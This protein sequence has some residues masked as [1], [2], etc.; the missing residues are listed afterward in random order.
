[1]W[2]H[3]IF[4]FLALLS[5]LGWQLSVRP[6][7]WFITITDYYLDIM[8]DAKHNTIKKLILYA[9]F[10]RN[11]VKLNTQQQSVVPIHINRGLNLLVLTVLCIHFSCCFACLFVCFFHSFI[12]QLTEVY[13]SCGKPCL[14]FK[15]FE[16]SS[17]VQSFWVYSVS[18]NI[19]I[20]QH[21]AWTNKLQHLG[22]S[23]NYESVKMMTYF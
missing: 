9:I 11:T 18:S 8:L 10:S 12:S 5:K 13:I 20:V 4:A 22:I 23:C 17:S 7:L 19:S 6:H 14:T 1:M 15:W 3:I 2:C 21:G 16:K